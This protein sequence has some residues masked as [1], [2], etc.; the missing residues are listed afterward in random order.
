[1]AD[2]FEMDGADFDTLDALCDD[3]PVAPVRTR[4]PA[5]A[6]GRALPP[7]KPQPVKQVKHA[8]APLSAPN[9]AL[10]LAYLNVLATASSFTDVMAPI[11]G[12]FFD[13]SYNIIY[14]NK[15]TA[16]IR[17]QIFGDFVTPGGGVILTTSPD[18]SNSNKFDVLSNTANGRVES[19]PMI[20]L[21]GQTV[22]GRTL[23]YTNFP[24]TNQDIIRAR[25]FDVSKLLTV[26]RLYNF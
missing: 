2:D 13:D 24:M 12:A 9:Y 1:M 7:T 22:Y 18:A 11:Q 14:A 23:D 10:Q 17:I 16:P 4:V 21:P 3:M 8:S 25:I 26:G 5:A 15:G 20:L 19:V 6:Q